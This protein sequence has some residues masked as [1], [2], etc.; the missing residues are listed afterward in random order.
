M[1][2]NTDAPNGKANHVTRINDH[3]NYGTMIIMVLKIRESEA[4]R[5]NQGDAIKF[6][7]NGGIGKNMAN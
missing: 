6:R 3:F 7:N 4:V 1:N 5:K 2:D